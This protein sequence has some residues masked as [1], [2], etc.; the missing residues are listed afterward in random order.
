MNDS[1]AAGGLLGHLNQCGGKPDSQTDGKKY[2]R[3]YFVPL[4]PDTVSRTP[5]ILNPGAGLLRPRLDSRIV[6][7]LVPPC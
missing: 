4:A 2:L 3:Y 1:K 7:T 5:R 6:H